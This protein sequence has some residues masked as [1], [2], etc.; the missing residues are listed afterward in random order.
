MM[1]R[2]LG[3]LRAAFALLC[4]VGK[5]HTTRNVPF[6]T[7]GNNAVQYSPVPSNAS[8]FVSFSFGEGTIAEGDSFTFEAIS[9]GPSIRNCYL[10]G[11]ILYRS[12]KKSNQS[13]EIM[14]RFPK[15]DTELEFFVLF[16]NGETCQENIYVVKGVSGSYG[17]SSVSLDYAKI[18]IGESKGQNLWVGESDDEIFVGKTP[19]GAENRGARVIASGFV[20]GYRKWKDNKGY[21]HPLSNAK[22]LLSFAG[23]F[24]KPYTY[25]NSNGY[26][27]I[28]FSN[29]W[30]LSSF[31][32]TIHVFTENSLS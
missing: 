10:N 12:N 18:L 26:Y 5:R 13:F 4:G 25:T 32:C 3:L 24:G 14:I 20:R 15:E 31:Q 2:F 1:K 29:I 22:V 21:Q 11:N 17:I 7:K 6:N 19:K 30:T 27:E 8:P 23:S 16:G 9:S 28:D